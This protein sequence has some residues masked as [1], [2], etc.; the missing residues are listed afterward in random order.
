MLAA[1]LDLA[2]SRI[3]LCNDDGIHA[4]GLKVLER[5]ARSLS[6]DVWVFAPETEQSGA[7]HSLSLH[8]PIRCRPVGRRRFAVEGSPTDSVLIAI[9]EFLKDKPPDLVLSGVNRG[10][11]L[12]EDVTYSGTVAG[13]MEAAILGVPAIA[14]SQQIAPE[15]AVH[16]D[17]ALEHAG[18]VVRRLVSAPWQ[19][20]VFFNVNFPN[21]PATAVT[22]VRVVP[23][24]RRS[25]SYELLKVPDPRRRG[26]YLIGAAQRGDLIG[27]GASD[28]SEIER[29]AVTVTPLHVDLTH[30]G[31][32]RNFKALFP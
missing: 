6:K 32:L 8:R 12:G 17:A 2:T 10:A 14:L 18:E 11:N 30:R 27:R 7:S 5:I 29:G 26:Y 16:W 28:W 13:A 4:H 25:S 3:L 23:Q 1:P 21:R 19:R 20:D 22:G 24:G 15:K 31:M 9:T